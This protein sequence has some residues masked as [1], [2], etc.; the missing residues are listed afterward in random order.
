VEP[1]EMSEFLGVLQRRWYV[2]LVD[3]LASVGLAYGAS[4]VKPPEY[5]TRGLVVLLPS[6]AATDGGNP[7]L[8]LGGLDL[9]ARVVVSYYGS[10]TAQ[11]ELAKAFPGAEVA[12]SME[13]STRGPV[14]A[15][16]VTAPTEEAALASLEFVAASIP[17]TLDRMQKE[18]GAPRRTAVRVMPLAI[19][20]EAQVDGSGGTRL[21]ILAAG[22]GIAGFIALAS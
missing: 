1:V 2:V 20:T 13:E 9:P 12:V 6:T 15:V 16:D 7:F 21:M 22:V 19:D 5:T 4:V 17:S 3:L 14:I 18:V 11:S 8:S 10:A